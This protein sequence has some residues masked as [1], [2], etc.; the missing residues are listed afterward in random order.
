MRNIVILLKCQNCS[1]EEASS[2]SNVEYLDPEVE[3]LLRSIEKDTIPMI[4]DKSQGKLKAYIV[5]EGVPVSE[6]YLME[7]TI[8]K[9]QERL[10]RLGCNFKRTTYGKLRVEVDAKCGNI[11]LQHELRMEHN[12]QNQKQNELGGQIHG[13]NQKQNKMGLSK[14]SLIMWIRCCCCCD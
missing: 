10:G 1:V 9:G 12:A 8:I 4:L 6:K 3:D 11:T 13:T 14:K 7:T 5:P 2:S